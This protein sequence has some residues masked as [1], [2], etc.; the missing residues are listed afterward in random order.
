MA[1]FGRPEPR[2]PLKQFGARS[3]EVNGIYG[4][5]R[6]P[7]LVGGLLFL[8][9]SGPTLN[10]L[11]FTLMYALYMVVGSHYEERRLIRI[12]GSDYLAYRDRVGAFVPRLRPLRPAPAGN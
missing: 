9:T 6:H 3:L 7:M 2:T 8:I 10:T 4:W 12:F 1:L 11:V 5:V